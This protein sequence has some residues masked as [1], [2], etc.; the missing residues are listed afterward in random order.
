M[1]GA[2]IVNVGRIARIDISIHAPHA[3]CDKFEGLGFVFDG[4]FNPRT[5]CGVR[6]LHTFPITF[7]YSISIHAPHAGCDLQLADKIESAVTI[8]IHAPHAGC[9]KQ[10][11][12]DFVYRPEFQS[13][14]PMRG[15]TCMRQSAQIQRDISI[16]A[17]HAG[18]DKISSAG[19]TVGTNFNPRTPCGVRPLRAVRPVRRRSA[20]QSTH[21]MRGAT[22]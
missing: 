13:T 6:L 19:M 10:R 9:D 14:H 21:P 1:R 5:P 12:R 17:P 18:C 15:A 11:K 16:H 4:N 7:I 8:S 20:F 3:G 22:A 2:T